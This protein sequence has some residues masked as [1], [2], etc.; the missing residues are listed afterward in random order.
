MYLN[1][2]LYVIFLYACAFLIKRPKTHTGPTVDPKPGL[3]LQP[4]RQYSAHSSLPLSSSLLS[5]TTFLILLALLLQEF[6]ARQG[7]GYIQSSILI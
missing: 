1:T 3:S 7:V 2:Y 6:E 5:L 4:P